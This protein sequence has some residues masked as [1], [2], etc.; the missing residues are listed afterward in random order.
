MPLDELLRN[1][2]NMTPGQNSFVS[3]YLDLRPD[4]SGKK[5]YS[6]FLKNR[7]AEL[8]DCFPN[9]SPEQGFLTK[10]IKRIQKYLEEDLDSA[11]KGIA[12]F[13]CAA[14]NLFVSIPMPLPPENAVFLDP[15]P[16]LFSLVRHADLYKTHA[17]VVATSQ[18]A[19]LF[20]VRLGRLAE[21]LTLSWE[22]KHITRSGRVGWSERRSDKRFERHLQ[23]HIKQRAKEIVENLEKLIQ[24][25]KIEYLF[26]SA[27]EGMEAE[28]KKQFPAAGRKKFVSLPSLDT[29]SPDHKVLAVA[30]ESLHS[31]SRE[32]AE[33]L[34][35]QILDEAEPLGRASSG[36]E[37]TLSALQNHQ[38]ERLVFDAHF[39]ATGWRCLAC[40]SLGIGG[41]PK[42]CPF[43]QG[44]V[45]LVDL[46]EEIV[47]KAKSMSID[48]FF[49]ENFPPL[50]KAGG[51]AA[52]L[53]YQALK[54]S[55]R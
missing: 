9:H 30:S 14:E 31:I 35:K 52:L 19:R 44:R 12:L 4:G 53:K 42:T 46:R 43:C 1:F 32:K 24:L 54:K 22:E 38:I 55:P 23:E 6:L 21:H 7:L 13:A 17:V 34:A 45:Y 37:P 47:T 39:Q 18:H 20:L 8:S 48:L 41:L 5:R 40:S 15:S 26:V 33:G 50:L 51:V 3:V 28:L 27:E 25:E 29:H 49:T 36:P 2:I 10:D 11:L 16:C